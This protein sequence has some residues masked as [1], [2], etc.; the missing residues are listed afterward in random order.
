[1][2][3]GQLGTGGA[4]LDPE[5]EADALTGGRDGGRRQ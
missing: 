5:A 3:T 4:R 1:M 2:E